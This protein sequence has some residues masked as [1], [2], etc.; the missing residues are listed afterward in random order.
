[1]NDK[2]LLT[3]IIF[4]LT[5]SVNPCISQDVQ[6]YYNKAKEAHESNDLVGFYN[7]IKEAGRL[8]PFHQIIQYQL[9]IAAAL[10]GHAD[11]A[12]DALSKAIH[13][14]ATLD[15]S[16]PELKGLEKEQKFRELLTT[17]QELQRPVL[18]SDTAFTISERNAHIE[19]VVYDPKTKNF[20]LGSIHKRKI[21]VRNASGQVKDFVKSGEYGIMSVFGLR[22]DSRKRI[23]WACASPMPEM[24]NYDSTLQSAVYR[25]DL[26]SGKLLGKYS[27]A[28]P[29]NSVF[30]DLT[31]D[32]KGNAYVSD[33][34]TNTIY[35]VNEK[36]GMLEAYYT[37]DEFWNLQG[38]TFSSDDKFLFISD[39]I[40]GPYRLTCH[41]K[42]LIKLES[43]SPQ[44]LK[45]IDGLLFYNNSLIAIQNGVIPFRSTMHFLNTELN[46]I[47]RAS[48]IDRDH[49]AFHEP[50]IGCLDGTDFYYV[51]TSQWGAYDDDHHP[52]EEELKDI[53]ILH[54]NIS[55]IAGYR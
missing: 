7:N 20:Y 11:E 47:T 29:T 42:D 33:G 34:I 35:I 4:W 31:L 48:I 30:G 27:L 25:F 45:G 28:N 50:T 16:N 3:I 22:I 13:T 37:S 53:V 1:M 41:S 32:S 14:T 2:I 49:P 6:Y 10:N 39:Y 15:L 21:L 51:A 18:Q 54:K 43:N 17:Q 5:L 9:G 52:K 36:K 23:L 46:K 40:K 12:I 55:D 26:S 44:S 19:S 38:I 24:E 8:H